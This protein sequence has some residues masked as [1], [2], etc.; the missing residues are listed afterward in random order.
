MLVRLIMLTAATAFL[1]LPA[2]KMTVLAVFA[3]PDDEIAV[4]PL[5]AKYAAEGNDV[6]LATITS[7][8]V[9]GNNT[10]I[11]EGAELGA[12]REKELACSAK[13]LGIHKPFALGFQ[14]GNTASREALG[15]I[16][17]RV[18][19]VINKVKPDVVVTWGPDGMSGHPDHRIASAVTTE[20]FL[21]RE[22]LEDPPAKLYYV[23]IPASSLPE[24]ASAVGLPRMPG[25]V[26][27][28][29]LTTVVDADEYLDQTFAA[30]QCHVTQWAPVER[31]RKMFEMRKKLMGGKIY[32]RRVW[33]A[34]GDKEADI[35]AGLKK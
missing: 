8:Q 14:D 6:Y 22:L 9:G 34:S 33:P 3:H 28:E 26:S 31:M 4:A 35:L 30:M 12:A 16:V 29:F 32:L 2:E 24:D 17:E 15:P 10:D 11:P 7:G 13:R 18:R 1:L 21:R 20:V 19:E 27:D 5:L 25:A 23:E